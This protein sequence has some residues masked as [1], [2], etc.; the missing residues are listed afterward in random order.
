[1]TTQDKIVLACELLFLV[2]FVGWVYTRDAL[3]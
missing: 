1:M 3:Q 2:G